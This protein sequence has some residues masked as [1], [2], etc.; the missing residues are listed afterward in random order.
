[1]P[2]TPDF[3]WSETNES[4]FWIDSVPL[5]ENWQF[6]FGN[7]SDVFKHFLSYIQKMPYCKIMAEEDFMSILHKNRMNLTIEVLDYYLRYL[8]C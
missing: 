4:E 2:D 7:Y 3:S 5:S 6:G 8:K 1:M